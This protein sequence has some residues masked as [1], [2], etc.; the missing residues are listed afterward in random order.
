MTPAVLEHVHGADEIVF[1]ELTARGVPVDAGKDG[2][3]RGRIHD[4]VGSGQ[5]LEIGGESDV[6]M[7]DGNSERAK[8]GAVLLAAGAH[9]VVEA[10]Q[11]VGAPLN[12]AANQS[13][14]HEPAGAGE[15][16]FHETSLCCQASTI[17]TIVCSR[18]TVMSQ[19]G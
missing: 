16:D 3:I 17:W 19:S 11:L 15:E 9:E 13:G 12:P 1:D 18:P 7:M 5:R 4:D 8:G 6:G 10:D 14:S 2:W